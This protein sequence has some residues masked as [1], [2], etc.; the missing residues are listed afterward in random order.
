MNKFDYSGLE[1]GHRNRLAQI[2][3]E[4]Q[5]RTR[6]SAKL[7]WKN[8]RDYLEAQQILSN[9]GNGTF[10]QWCERVCGISSQTARNQ[11]HVFQC[12]TLDQLS[13]NR[14]AIS[15]LYKLSMSTTPQSARDEALSAD[16]PIS[17]AKATRMRAQAI[18]EQQQEQ[19]VDR[20]AHA[21]SQSTERVAAFVEGL[22]IDSPEKVELLNRWEK[23]GRDSIEEV[24]SS[25]YL[26]HPTEPE[27][28]VEFATAPVADISAV[29]RAKSQL[30][31]QMASADS[32]L[33]TSSMPNVDD[34][35]HREMVN[36]CKISGSRAIRG[37]PV[38]VRVEALREMLKEAGGVFD[39]YVSGA[40]LP[41]GARVSA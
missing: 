9:H 10:E 21:L 31:A 26:Q 28:S 25:G 40:T 38:D 32:Q 2:E 7:V 19:R 6:K 4:T 15:A 8:G 37:F 39:D 34:Q 18:A 16:K 23:H 27:S 29:M 36:Q 24:L 14:F 33:T 20:L 11:I 13:Q 12:F 30:H 5:V 17:K 35:R 1:S 3:A 41:A 22:G